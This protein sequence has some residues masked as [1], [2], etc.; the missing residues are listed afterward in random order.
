MCIIRVTTEVHVQV[1]D[2]RCHHTGMS[3]V[4]FD[5]LPEGTLLDVDIYDT[6]GSQVC[7]QYPDGSVAVGVPLAPLSVI[8]ACGGCIDPFTPQP[9][10]G[11][12]LGLA[13]RWTMDP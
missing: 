10:F 5:L 13:P 1:T 4:S 3:E 9:G 11:R 6:T 7:Y 8:S 12:P 2:Y